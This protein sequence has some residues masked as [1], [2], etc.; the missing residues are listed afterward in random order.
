MLPILSI[1]HE[2]NQSL[3]VSVPACPLYN[4]DAIVERAAPIRQKRKPNMSKRFQRGSICLIGDVWK[5]RY[6]QDDPAGNKR[7]HSKADLGAKP[8]TAQMEAKRKLADIIEKSG[9][10]KSHYVERLGVPADTF[11]QVRDAWEKEKL[12]TLALG[13]RTELPGQ[14]AM[15]FFLG[16]RTT[17]RL[18]NSRL[19]TAVCNEQLETVLRWA[20]KKVGLKAATMHSSKHGRISLLDSPAFQ[21]RSFRIMWDRKTRGRI[22]NTGTGKS[23]NS[24]I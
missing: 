5:G 1:N 9:V 11:T 18:F 10:T 2:S 12:P 7:K 24:M 4:V 23:R 8:Q 6:W 17:G 16:E 3:L 22:C 13:S 21:P 19:G 14:L 15:H 20:T